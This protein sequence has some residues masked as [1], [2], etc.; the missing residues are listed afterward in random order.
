MKNLL[1]YKVVLLKI[2]ERDSSTL[3][4]ILNVFITIKIKGKIILYIL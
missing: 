3:N 2:A 4:R 1:N